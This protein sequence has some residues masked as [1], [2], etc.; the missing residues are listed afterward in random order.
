M[1]EKIRNRSDYLLIFILYIHT[2]REK[3]R[4]RHAHIR[5]RL[6][7]CGQG[8]RHCSV[9]LWLQLLFWLNILSRRRIKSQSRTIPIYAPFFCAARRRKEAKGKSRCNEPILRGNKCRSGS[10]RF[11]ST[12]F[13]NIFI[14]IFGAFFWLLSYCWRERFGYKR[15]WKKVKRRID[16]WR[17]C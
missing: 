6:D 5:S 9:S 15:S 3:R 13:L 8:R 1:G 7:A 14:F 12:S 17:K 16:T 11:Y 4:N 10:S 2:H